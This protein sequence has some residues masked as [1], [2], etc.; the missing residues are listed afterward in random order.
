MLENFSKVDLTR[1]KQFLKKP[2]ASVAV[3]EKEVKSLKD[4]KFVE[5]LY[6][7]LLGRKSDK[8]GYE[9]HLASIKSGA[10]TREKK[11]EQFLTCIEYKN[12]NSG[13]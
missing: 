13:K 9:V 4:E 11:I 6:D 1:A 7:A 2:K 10:C 5:F 3:L 12:L 8:H